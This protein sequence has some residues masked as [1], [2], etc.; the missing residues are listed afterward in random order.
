MPQSHE[1]LDWLPRI[2]ADEA[3]RQRI[4]V[5]NPAGLYGF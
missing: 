5:D 1:L 4:L 3:K 2:G